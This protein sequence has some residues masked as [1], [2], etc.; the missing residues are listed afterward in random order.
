MS[1]LEPEPEDR[2]WFLENA[3]DEPLIPGDERPA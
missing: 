2:L 1:D 3:A